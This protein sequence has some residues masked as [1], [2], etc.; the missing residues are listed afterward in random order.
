MQ[1]KEKDKLLTKMIKNNECNK[2][3]ECMDKID[4]MYED[5]ISRKITKLSI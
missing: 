5:K 1:Y 2:F 3:M 4:K